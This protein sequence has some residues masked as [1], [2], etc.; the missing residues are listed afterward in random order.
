VAVAIAAGAVLG[1]YHY[2]LDAILG[3]AIAAASVALFPS[4]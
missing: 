2:L 4:A 3:A 1:R